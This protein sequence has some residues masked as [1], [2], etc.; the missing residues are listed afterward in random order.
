DISAF[1]CPSDGNAKK[2]SDDTFG[3]TSYFGCRGDA[4]VGWDS[5]NGRGIFRVGID[6]GMESIT[7]GTSNTV[8]FSE[9]L[10][11]EADQ[12]DQNNKSGLA[13]F[14]PATGK[15][16]ECDVYRGPSGMIQTV[17]G[18]GRKG[19]RWGDGPSVFCT[20]NTMLPPNSVSCS[21]YSSASTNT[22]NGACIV[23][24]TSN[25]AGGVNIALTDASV[26]FISDTI[27]CGTQTKAHLNT[28]DKGTSPFGIWGGLGTIG[29]GDDHL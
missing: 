21:F 7:D 16:S 2:S 1:K 8:I 14:I 13:L 27:N 24:A 23:T 22:N 19:W 6:I 29:Q 26:R 5:E 9:S 12:T 15:P 11:S 10:V 4:Y 3:I 17:Y 20:F 25:H 18:G 28:P